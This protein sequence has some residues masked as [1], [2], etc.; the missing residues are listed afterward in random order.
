MRS[1][2]L[3]LLCCVS[4]LLGLVDAAQAQS[5]KPAAATR[6][7][8]ADA[9]FAIQGEYAGTI[10]WNGYWQAVGLQVVALGNGQ[11]SALLYPGG[12]PGNGYNG[13]AKTELTGQRQDD[14]ALL[15][16][17]DLQ[18]QLKPGYTATVTSAAGGHLGFLQPMRRYSPTTGARPPANAR[19]LFDGTDTGALKNAKISE[20]GLLQVGAETV[21]PVT[22]FILH[23][24]FKTPYMPTARGQARG[25]S[26]F[27]LQRRYEVQVLDSFGLEPA[28][29]EAASLYRFRAP[30]MNM[31]FPPLAWQTYDIHFTAARFNDAGEKVSPARITVWHNGV[32]VQNNLE[33][34][35]KTGGGRPEGPEPLP[36]LFQN[37][38]DP[39]EF[40]NMW[41]VDTTP[42]SSTTATSV[43][44]AVPTTTCG[45][46]AAC[47]PQT[48][49]CCTQ[50]T[51]CRPAKSPRLGLFRRAR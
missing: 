40:R 51:T 42:A 3:R 27:Y 12:L 33:L 24:E 36:I 13:S 15:T 4:L 41:L 8:D 14:G 22:D 39:V 31:S 5:K 48:T 34:E 26:G 38:S 9:D 17:G 35:N 46:A 47:C 30:D 16:G 10:A 29:N 6:V 45:Q 49:A 43:T 7:E 32:I 23:G 20:E 19:I 2:S 28:F 44:H 11:F 50:A 1:P 25:N 18:V 21:E 37:H